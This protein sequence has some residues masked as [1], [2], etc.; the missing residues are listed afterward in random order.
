MTYFNCGC[1]ADHNCIVLCT[2]HYE[3]YKK[4]KRIDHQKIVVIKR[5]E[6]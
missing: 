2:K 1:H 6:D 4:T 5:K 3:T